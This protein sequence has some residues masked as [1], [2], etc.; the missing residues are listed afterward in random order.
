[1]YPIKWTNE[2]SHYNVHY[3]VSGFWCLFI[4]ILVD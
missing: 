4:C 3:L 1:M 2:K